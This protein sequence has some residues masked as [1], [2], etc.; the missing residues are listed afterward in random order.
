MTENPPIAA[1]A[2][3]RFAASSEKIFDA[4]LD[5]DMLRQ[6]M[7][8]PNVRDEEVVRLSLDARVGGSF[9]FVVRR[10]GAEVNHIGE[11]LE[12]DRPN[13]LAFTWAIEDVGAS[14]RVI[15]NITPTDGGCEC[16]VTHEMHP[17]WVEYVEQAA[18]AW[19]EMLDALARLLGEQGDDA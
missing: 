14:S 3:R 2:S 5:T 17:D 11:Y 7:F 1:R 13:R 8:G 9:S 4:W 10:N 6:W 16:E 15:I 19:T 12:I 18:A